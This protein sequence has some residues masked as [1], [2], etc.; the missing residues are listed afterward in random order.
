MIAHPSGER[1]LAA[2]AGRF[3]RANAA[4]IVA[5]GVDWSFVTVLVAAGVHYL[6]AAA[7]GAVG[8]AVTDF[9]LKRHWAFDRPAMA[10]TWREGT[11]YAFVSG[12]SL[13]WN[14]VV[15]WALVGGLG[16]PA[17]PGV[18]VAS[19]VVGLAWNYPLHRLFVFRAHRPWA[20]VCD[21]DGT[22][23]LDDLA[24][25]L[26]IAA[27]GR[28]KW[29]EIEDS[30][31]AGKIDF[32]GLLRGIFEPIVTTP[33]AVREF[34]RTHARFRPGFER[35]LRTCRERR[36]P[37][38]LASGGLDLYIHP[39][40]ELLPPEVVEGLE[41]RANHAEITPTGLV[42]SFPYQHAPGACGTCGSCK[43]AI[44]RG[45]Q[46]AGYRVLAVG[47]GN[48]DRCMAGV[49]DV[50]YARGRLLDWCTRQGIPCVPFERL[51]PVA[52]RVG[53]GA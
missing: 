26:S 25:A 5:T 29:Q 6:G 51:E 11:R 16:M 20:V 40:L 7:A 24:D 32:V 10:S 2:E 14:L 53:R 22:A 33:E 45:L 8:G 27:I 23:T 34:V 15:A 52:E 37:F 38:V 18:I 36:I 31:Q 46:G 3:L 47:D 4:S 12:S 44:V 1:G 48:A 19:I 9:L 43:G 41:V 17:V 39:A 50:L 28:D 49:A 21:F 42:L 13:L 35:L 30:Y